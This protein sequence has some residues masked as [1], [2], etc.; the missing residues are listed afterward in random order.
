[1]FSFEF[2]LWWLFYYPRPTVNIHHLY[3]FYLVT[4]AWW[5]FSLFS[6]F[7]EYLKIVIMPGFYKS[8]V[9]KV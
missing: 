7:Y 4:V 6:L 8:T 1:M 3:S 9:I 5:G 2:L